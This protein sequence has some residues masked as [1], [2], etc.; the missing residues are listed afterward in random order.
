MKRMIIALLILML[1]VCGAL[2]ETRESVIYLEGEPEDVTETLYETPWGFYFWYD[3][4]LF[5]V[6]DSQSESGQS[7][8]ICPA[9]SDLPVY[10]ELM[11]PKAV[12]VPAERFL[13][14]NG[15]DEMN[16]D[17]YPCEAGGVL[18]G[19]ADYAAF[20]E[21][22]LQGFYVAQA[23]DE[24][25]AAYINCPVE[26]WEGYGHRLDR[27]LQTI[28]FGPLPAVR[29][30]E[31]EEDEDIPSVLIGDE[32]YATCVVFTAR[33]PVKDFQVLELE[34]SEDSD[35]LEFVTTTV[36]TQD[37]LTPDV[38]W[39][40]FNKVYGSFS[41]AKERATACVETLREQ[42][43]EFKSKVLESML[44]VANASRED[45]NESNVSPEEMAFI[46]QIREA[47][48]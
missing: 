8:M 15:M 28:A 30:E 44:K 31:V 42:S 33:R 38:S 45:E 23:G 9:E 13:E 43:P 39:D 12:G 3:A 26:A 48:E 6:D 46:Q 25:A 11:T 37:E 18:K 5:T 19:F 24:W 41:S 21:E 47:L 40:D 36:Y 17:E 4:E 32:D 10:L 14:V 20:N 2:A 1:S 29:V 7:L 34:M 22:I 35:E 27:I 16:E